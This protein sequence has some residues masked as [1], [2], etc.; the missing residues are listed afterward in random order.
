MAE[1]SRKI[2]VLSRRLSIG[3]IPLSE[4]TARAVLENSELFSSMVESN[5]DALLRIGQNVRF[6]L[7]EAIFEA[8]DEGD[9]MFVLLEGEA[10]VE[11]GGRF[12]RL[13]PGDFFGEMSLLAPAKRMATVRATRPVRALKVPHDEFQELLLEHPWIA[14]SMLKELVLRLREVE[15]R[16]DAWMAPTSGIPGRGPAALHVGP[17]AAD[18]AR[19]LRRRSFM[20]GAR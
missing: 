12:H 11:V 2:G 16:I 5:V 14:L 13:Q 17:A 4:P 9:G 19:D 1:S 8:G 7:D 3:G 10:E 20:G 15:Q 6:A 18:D